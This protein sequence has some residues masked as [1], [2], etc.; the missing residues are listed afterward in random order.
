VGVACSSAGFQLNIQAE[1]QPENSGS[2]ILISQ[3]M[4]KIPGS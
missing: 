4:A 2:K 3:R 1:P